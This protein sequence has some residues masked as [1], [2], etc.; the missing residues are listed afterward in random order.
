MNHLKN[1]AVER[2][3]ATERYEEAMNERIDSVKRFSSVDEMKI[4]WSM[5]SLLCAEVAQR[6]NRGIDVSKH[7]CR[8]FCRKSISEEL[9]FLTSQDQRKVEIHISLDDIQRM[10]VTWREI[11]LDLFD[12]LFEP[13][14]RGDDSYNDLLDTL[15]LAGEEFYQNAL[16]KTFDSNKELHEA[17]GKAVNNPFLKKTILNGENYFRRELRNAI[18]TYFGFEAWT[19]YLDEGGEE[20]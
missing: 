4:F 8:E 12:P 5:V 19:D 2:H 13:A 9:S 20:E 10:L 6:K 3:K 16:K 1:L 17:V 18:T 14:E 11:T 7:A 15:P